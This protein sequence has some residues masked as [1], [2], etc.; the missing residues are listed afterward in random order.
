MISFRPLG[1]FGQRSIA[2]DCDEIDTVIE[3][4]IELVQ[5]SKNVQ[6]MEDV[7]KALKEVT[8]FKTL[9][10]TKPEFM[11]DMEEVKNGSLKYSIV[12]HFLFNKAPSELKSPNESAGWSISR[13]SRWLEDHKDENDRLQ[14][15]KGALES[16]AAGTRLRRE[17]SYVAPYP[18]MIQ[19]L[20]EALNHNSKA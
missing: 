2:F 10:F 8:A 16:Y 20:Q 13:Y 11:L 19:L 15:I 7:E 1:R 3:P 14:L 18:I 12:L 9:L 5:R 17:K 6:L 4:L